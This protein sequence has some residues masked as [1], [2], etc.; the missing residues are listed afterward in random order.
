[1]WPA[2]AGGRMT[3]MTLADLDRLVR[4]AAGRPVVLD[5]F[6]PVYYDDTGASLEPLGP[7]LPEPSDELVLSLLA[8]QV[9]RP[10][11]DPTVGPRFR[12]TGTGCRAPNFWAGPRT[13]PASVGRQYSSF[14]DPGPGVQREN[15]PPP[16]EP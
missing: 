2:A 8:D 9:E 5:A 6:P 13:T 14:R 11:D 4:D 12:R 10:A 15:R 3:G 7:E 16:V 1:L